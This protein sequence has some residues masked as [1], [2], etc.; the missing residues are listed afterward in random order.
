M[1]TFSGTFYDI[2]RRQHVELWR[3]FFKHRKKMTGMGTSAGETP[4]T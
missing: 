3:F 2:A 4:A 1:T